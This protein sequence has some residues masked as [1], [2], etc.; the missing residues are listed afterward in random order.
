MSSNS[1]SLSKRWGL[2]A[3]FLALIGAVALPFV[4]GDRSRGKTESTQAVRTSGKPLGA[5]S[6]SQPVATQAATAADAP[7][8][9]A[10]SA[11]AN[12]FQAYLDA[13][14]NTPGAPPAQ[15]ASPAALDPFRAALK[16]RVPSQPVE[17]KDDPF[18]AALKNQK[19]IQSAFP[20]TAAPSPDGGG[21]SSGQQ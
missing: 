19:P 7:A 8:V 1:Y 10:V 2:G 20:F 4:V 15:P 11:Q 13:H 17:V 18:R 16:A 5:P 21:V 3:V 14:G 9:P 12:P 6:V